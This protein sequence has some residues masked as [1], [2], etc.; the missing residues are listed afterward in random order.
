MGAVAD[1]NKGLRYWSS[2]LSPIGYQSSECAS[3]EHA[4]RSAFRVTEVRTQ[5]ANPSRRAGFFRII[6]SISASE[7]PW[8]LMA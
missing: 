4:V 2:L 6:K 7:T 3:C 5:S 1:L 8:R